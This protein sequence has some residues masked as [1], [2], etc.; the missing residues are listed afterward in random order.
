MFSISGS[1]INAFSWGRDCKSKPEVEAREVSAS[2]PSTLTKVIQV[3]AFW[4]LAGNV[5]APVQR[6][7]LEG[8]TEVHHRPQRRQECRRCGD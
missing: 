6:L 4:I 3:S 7:A 1:G 5:L 8:E 2:F